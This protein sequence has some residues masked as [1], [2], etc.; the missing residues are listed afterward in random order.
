MLRRHSSARV[1]SVANGWYTLRMWIS[2]SFAVQTVRTIASIVATIVLCMVAAASP[3]HAQVIR[4]RLIDSTT[5][6]PI[7]GALVSASSL[8]RTDV[9]DGLTNVAGVANLRVPEPGVYSIL[10]RRI[11]MRPRSVSDIRVNSSEIAQLE[12]QLPQA[13]QALPTV[14][15]VAEAGKCGRAP[16]GEVRAAVLW[17]Q[18]TLALRASTLTRE[19]AR[20]A[21]AIQATVYERELSPSLEELSAKVLSDQ[22]GS[23][24]PFLAADP[25]QLADSGY[26][27]ADTGKFVQYF[28]PDERVLL[29]ESFLR[30]HCFDSPKR[31]TDPAFAELRFYPVRDRFVPDVS[32]T[33]FVDAQSGELRRIE[34]KFVS[35][36]RFLQT[37]AP[38]SGGVV[39]LERLDD[40]RWIVSEWS[41]RMP[42]IVARFR[43]LGYRLKGYREVGGVAHAVR[44]P[45]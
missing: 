9:I 32:G 39:W 21:S 13:R 31:D 5:S 29:S 33:A 44:A 15:V 20:N 4:V 25:K 42:I 38:E 11:G 35:T 40:Q 6:E 17:E 22:V 26:V 2:A 36:G 24:R 16:E 30:T 18:I 12:L 27:R 3:L 45:K 10:V 8:T 1:S 43:G 41:I 34:F 7:V 14:R 37:S 28:A 23:T 19:D